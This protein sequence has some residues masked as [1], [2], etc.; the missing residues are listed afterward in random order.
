[1]KSI[2]EK[3]EMVI[4][5]LG[6]AANDSELAMAKLLEITRALNQHLKDK[7]I[8]DAMDIVV[9]KEIH[10]IMGATE[11]EVQR[12]WTAV[13]YLFQRDWWYRIWVRQ[14]ATTAVHTRIVC[15]GTW[16]TRDAVMLS[17]M[18]LFKPMDIPENAEMASRSSLTNATQL[19]MFSGDR[20][21]GGTTMELLNL[22]QSF[23]RYEA[24]D[25]RDKVHAI[26]PLG[27]PFSVVKCSSVGSFENPCFLLSVSAYENRKTLLCLHSFLR[28]HSL[29]C[30]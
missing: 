24:T 7:G 8:R 6:P 4:C 11:P 15:G 22:L 20:L 30:L 18:T 17:V 27:K 26:L 29:T 1:M 25:P 23:T 28:G 5:W 3:A 13:E 19:W 9:S 10:S 2:Y 21:E 16:M 14:E 12:F